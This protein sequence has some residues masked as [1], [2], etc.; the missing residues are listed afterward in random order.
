MK[1]PTLAE[2]VQERTHLLDLLARALLA[3]VWHDP[4]AS[5]VEVVRRQIEAVEFLLAS[6]GVRG[7][8]A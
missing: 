2:L 3:H 7:V 4:G 8:A 5:D 1:I 6:R